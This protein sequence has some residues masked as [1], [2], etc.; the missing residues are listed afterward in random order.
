MLKTCFAHPD[1][2]RGAHAAQSAVK[3]SPSVGS[4]KM[5]VKWIPR[6][7][8]DLMCQV[9]ITLW[10]LA[11]LP[12]SHR[13]QFVNWTVWVIFCNFTQ[14]TFFFKSM[15]KRSFARELTSLTLSSGTV[16]YRTSIL[17]SLFCL[18][19]VLPSPKPVGLKAA[20]VTQLWKWHWNTPRRARW[21]WEF[22]GGSRWFNCEVFGSGHFLTCHLH[23]TDVSVVNFHTAPSA[24]EAP[25]FRRNTNQVNHKKLILTLAPV[26]R[27]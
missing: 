22:T 23:G 6:A 12:K 7:S 14:Q 5:D 4:P 2:G 19:E 16:I 8:E 24:I 13:W 20:L 15:V 17:L 11:K 3:R 18:L 1:W 9:A 10:V 27:F 21:R 26:E 25:T